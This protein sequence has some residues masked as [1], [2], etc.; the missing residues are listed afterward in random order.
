MVSE[1]L[2]V[3]RHMDQARHRLRSRGE[4]GPYFGMATEA[5]GDDLVEMRVLLTRKG[6][7]PCIC[8]IENSLPATCGVSLVP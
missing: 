8:G 4:K 7:S 6:S 2:F 3:C 5:I 1:T